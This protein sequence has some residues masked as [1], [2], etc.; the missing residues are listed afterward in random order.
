MCS[1]ATTL[2]NPVDPGSAALV[3]WLKWWFALLHMWGGLSLG[4]GGKTV[5]HQPHIVTPTHA[6]QI[7]LDTAKPRQVAGG[8][9]TLGY[10]TCSWSLLVKSTST[11]APPAR[12]ARNCTTSSS[13]T[14][15]I[16]Y[17]GRRTPLT[18]VPAHPKVS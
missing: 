8:S 5:L 6:M 11:S 13:A 3:A 2:R 1:S 7:S 14:A 10:H 18:G 4:G 9:A 15:R 17:E 12:A 16:R